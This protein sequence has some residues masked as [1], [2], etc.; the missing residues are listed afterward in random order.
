MILAVADL[1]AATTRRLTVT[2]K[3]P[4]RNRRL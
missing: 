4:R 1:A 3:L 2:M